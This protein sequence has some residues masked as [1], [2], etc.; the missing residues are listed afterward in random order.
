[1]RKKIFVSVLFFLIVLNHSVNGQE[2]LRTVLPVDFTILQDQFSDKNPD[3]QI[4]RSLALNNGLSIFQV[5]INFQANVFISIQR[6]S[7]TGQRSLS[8]KILN[9]KIS[10]DTRF[11]DFA[12]DSLLMPT[13]VFGTINLQQAKDTIASFVIEFQ[14]NNTSTTNVLPDDLLINADSISAGITIESVSY[15]GRDLAFY[16]ISKLINSYYAYNEILKE[17]IN[18]YDAVSLKAENSDTDIF[19]AWHQISRVN[20]YIQRLDFSKTL[21]LNKADPEGF[22]KRYSTSKRMERRAST[23]FQQVIRKDEKGNL[24]DKR[25][26]CF[27]YAQLSQKYLE[28]AHNL[29]PYL[30]SGFEEVAQIYPSQ[31]EK[32]NLVELAAFYGVF[33]RIENT[34][35]PQ[36][37]HTHFVDLAKKSFDKNQFVVSL[38]LLK[39]AIQIKEWF[40]DIIVSDTFSTIYN[41][42]LDGV[43]T[44]YLRVSI[45][46]YRAG[47]FEMADKYYDKALVI[48][49]EYGTSYLV[50]DTANPSFLHFTGQQLEL[51]QDLLADGEYYKALTLLKQARNIRNCKAVNQDCPEIDALISTALR[52]IF[53]QK[54]DTIDDLLSNRKYDNAR[55]SLSALKS[56]TLDYE[57]YFIPY[58]AKY[59]LPPATILFQTF[60]DWGEDML[61]GKQPERALDFFLKAQEVERAY[62]FTQNTR[63]KV[64]VYNATVPVILKEIEKA[65]FETWA[66]RMQNAD[67]IYRQAKQM[68]YD[69][70]Q[71]K[72]EELVAV[73]MA[74]ETKMEQRKCINLNR[75]LKNLNVLIVNR[76]QSRKFDLARDYLQEA[77]SILDNQVNCEIDS[78]ETRR[79]EKKYAGLFEYQH[80]LK[81]TNI[82]IRDVKY[83]SAIVYFVLL[84]NYYSQYNLQQF[85]VDKPSL[86]VFVESADHP[87]LT[88]EAISY[89]IQSENFMEALH[90]LDVLKKQKVSSWEAKNLQQLTGRGIGYSDATD[91]QVHK[92][93]QDDPWY[94]YFKLARLTTKIRK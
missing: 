18:E 21:N 55:V 59:F 61:N 71:E 57:A 27:A 13:V 81:K 77:D 12:I 92:I 2:L 22:L 5:K 45:I 6:D 10:G 32:T 23:L 33:N 60:Y 75:Q 56:F 43:M 20:N 49:E 58:P 53:I 83:D 51:S 19:I 76:V 9:K 68:Q 37:I 26:Y 48:F 79:I 66:N 1:M 42:S 28:R 47:K 40:Q 88:K 17:L 38:Q 73:F 70:Q 7:V 30:A 93:T 25:S 31:E 16:E 36:L 69:F 62:L 64:L 4:L 67:S 91:E 84:I 14:T 94:I 44:S 89:L 11:R 63:L 82:C 52:G 54:L 34:S 78:L 65:D 29:Q 74:L 24:A 3:K 35:T 90:F 39:N 86:K 46:A 15:R 50:N 41:H 87:E 72:N 8:A 80:K 85:G